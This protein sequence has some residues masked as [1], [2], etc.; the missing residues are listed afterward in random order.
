M[1]AYKKFMRTIVAVENIVL[2]VTMV[3]I[4]VLTFAN[5]VGRFGF[6]H[7]LAFAD[8]L[9]VAV[10]VLVS[11]MGAALAA[12]EDGGLVGLSL[13]SDRL[14]GTR[15]SVQKLVANAVSI[16]YCVI[17]TYQGLGRTMTDYSQ[18]VHTFVLHWP[19]WIFWAFVPVSGVF[20]VLHFIEN[21]LDFIKKSKEGTV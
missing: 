1:N 19:K 14:S 15:R 21:T 18:N 12:R 8:E 11:L 13:I 6:N 9:V 5:V 3:V 4:L 2:V 10:F 7:S 17:L 20:L 16:V